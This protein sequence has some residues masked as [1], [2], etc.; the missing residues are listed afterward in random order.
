MSP[1]FDRFETSGLSSLTPLLRGKGG[2][3]YV[4]EFSDGTQYV[5]QAVNFVTRMTTHRRGGGNHH[6]PWDDIVAVS[7]MN[8]PLQEMGT[9]ER[10]VIDERRAAG[11][12]LRN[13][14]FNFGF[15]GPSALDLV[16]PVEEQTHWATGG[17]DYSLSQ[18]E[19]AARRPRGAEPRL[20]KSKDGRSRLQ[21]GAEWRASRAEVVVA[22]LA[23][24]LSEAVP[25]APRLEA[26]FWTLSDYPST[27]GG[28]YATL[29]VG[30]LELAYFPR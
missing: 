3:I 8:V 17:G 5:G 13:K 28:R 19:E 23:V 12:V 16:L 26:D 24:I 30:G 7:V 20:F 6:G 4:L 9:W 1:S 2:G 21:L 14:A 18:Y 15:L 10:R 11:V 25:D 27:G 22:A 29:N